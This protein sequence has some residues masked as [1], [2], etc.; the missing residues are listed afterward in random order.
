MENSPTQ[1]Y[2][3]NWMRWFLARRL[4]TVLRLLWWR[5]EDVNTTNILSSKN[6]P[7]PLQAL[8]L[9]KLHRKYKHTLQYSTGE[10]TPPCDTPE[11]WVKVYHR[12]VSLRL[13]CLICSGHKYRKPFEVLNLEHI[14]LT[15]QLY[16]DLDRLK[17]LPV[18]N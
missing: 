4:L 6:A 3:V 5:G 13:Y 17:S 7:T 2:M 9:K 14:M 8:K 18:N 10:R 12:E 15:T 1:T 11:K 16:P